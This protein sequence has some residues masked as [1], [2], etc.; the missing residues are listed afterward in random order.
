MLLRSIKAFLTEH[1]LLPSQFGRR[2]V[3]DPRFVFDLR[4]GRTPRRDTEVRVRAW[5]QGFAE[6]RQCA[7]SSSAAV[8]RTRT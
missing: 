2:V 5:M 8:A 3:G 1:D 7:R 6:G 4:K